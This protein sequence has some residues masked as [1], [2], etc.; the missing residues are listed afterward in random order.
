M[1]ILVAIPAMI[2][3]IGRLARIR[4]LMAA[5]M[6]H[7]IRVSPAQV[8][9]GLQNIVVVAKKPRNRLVLMR[10]G[11]VSALEVIVARPANRLVLN[12]KLCLDGRLAVNIVARPAMVVERLTAAAV[13][14]LMKCHA[15]A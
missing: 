1:D 7:I 5:A 13:V 6:K 2:P 10:S 12:V 8:L 14:Q 11:T 9:A 4:V 3:A 15:Q